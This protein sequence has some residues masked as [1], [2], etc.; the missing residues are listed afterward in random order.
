MA[1]KDT[2][3]GH[4]TLGG[5]KGGIGPQGPPGPSGGEFIKVDSVNTSGIK[6][7]TLASAA[8][9]EGALAFV[10]TVGGYFGLKQSALTV[11]NITVVNAT[12][13]AGFQWCRLDMQS[14][15]WLAKTTWFIDPQNVTA[16]DENNGQAGGTPLKTFGELARRLYGSDVAITPT[17]NLLSDCVSTDTNVTFVG[18]LALTIVGTPTVI[19][20][21]TVSGYVAQALNAA[22]D[23]NQLTDSTIPVSYTAS[24]LLANGILFQDTTRGFWFYGAKDLGAK[25]A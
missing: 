17:V 21:G 20:T 10:S 24:G 1:N 23:D 12:G 22:A 2:G 13:K 4:A 3:D 16:N 7:S 25:T 15:F 18:N 19:Y 14:R 5:K 11:D 9:N 8:F 6:L